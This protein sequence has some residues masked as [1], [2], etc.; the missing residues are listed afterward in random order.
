MGLYQP[1]LVQGCS[2]LH[3]MSATLLSRVVD[4]VTSGHMYVVDFDYYVLFVYCCRFVDFI[5]SRVS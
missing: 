5:H 2:D 1:C 3:H 4:G